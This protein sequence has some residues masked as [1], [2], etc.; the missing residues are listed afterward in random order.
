MTEREI[1]EVR[2]LRSEINDLER[3]IELMRGALMNI[4][5]LRNC[6]PQGHDLDS[7]VE[8]TVVEIGELE[9]ELL[10]LKERRE[11]A[12]INITA[13]ICAANLTGQEAAVIY[14]RY[15]KCMRFRDICFELNYS[16]AHVFRLHGSA[17]KKLI[18][19]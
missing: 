17:L 7:R 19:E 16:D 13:N 4:V 1:N 9:E 18:V 5:P 12:K 10:E 14:S 15:V 3:K 11:L 2:E 6:M 8:K